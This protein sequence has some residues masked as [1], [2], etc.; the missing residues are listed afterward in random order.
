MDSQ[1]ATC[2]GR[3]GQ[4][5]HFTSHPSQSAAKDGAP[6]LLW[7]L[8]RFRAGAGSL[9]CALYGPHESFFL[10]QTW[11]PDDIKRIQ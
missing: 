9:F 3:V 4:C 1:V 7:L 10:D 8:P 6:G 2:W 11:K 5:W